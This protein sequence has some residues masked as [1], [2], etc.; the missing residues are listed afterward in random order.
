MKCIGP[1]SFE[2]PSSDTSAQALDVR[3]DRNWR[4]VINANLMGLGQ[5]GLGVLFT[6]GVACSTW[7]SPKLWP[8]RLSSTLPLR[9]GWL[10]GGQTLEF[11][12]EPVLLVLN[13][14]T[15]EWL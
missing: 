1:A 10:T 3:T 6:I 7:G 8:G 9:C 5:C 4:I 13:H 15:T 2:A 12:G 11:T 14:L